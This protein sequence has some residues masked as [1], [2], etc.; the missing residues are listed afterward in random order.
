MIS[1]HKTLSHQITS[2]EITW[3]QITSHHITSH[4]IT[5][6]DITWHEIT[7]NQITSHHITSHH[8]TSNH[9]T[10]HIT[11]QPICRNHYHNHCHTLWHTPSSRTLLPSD[12]CPYSHNIRI[13]LTVLQVFWIVNQLLASQDALS[14]IPNSE[15]TV[16]TKR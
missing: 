8:I 5:S 10:Q 7:W 2:H 11:I 14:S 16:S 15:Q 12:V 3:N 13:S 4:E 1:Y 9:I 6:H